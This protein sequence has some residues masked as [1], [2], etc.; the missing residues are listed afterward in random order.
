MKDLVPKD[1][2]DCSGIEELRNL[3]DEEIIP[4]LPDLLAWI[5]NIWRCLGH[6]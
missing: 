1:E 3:S 5:K 2:F 6:R 4:V